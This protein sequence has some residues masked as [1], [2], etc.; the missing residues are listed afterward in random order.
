MQ[1]ALQA[2][3]VEVPVAGQQG[4]CPAARCGDTHLALPRHSAISA[5]LFLIMLSKNLLFN[6]IIGICRI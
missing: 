5:C 3:L 2:V 6:T 4:R 1:F